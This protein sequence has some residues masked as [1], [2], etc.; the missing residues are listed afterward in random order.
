MAER[1]LAPN[2]RSRM[3]LSESPQ[4]VGHKA[5]IGGAATTTMA[6]WLRWQVEGVLAFAGVQRLQSSRQI[7][8]RTA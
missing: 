1:A 7:P 2:V 3:T 8:V 6:A 5:A 4:A